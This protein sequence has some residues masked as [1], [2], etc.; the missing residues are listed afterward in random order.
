MTDVQ[1]KMLVLLLSCPLCDVK[2]VNPFR[3]RP[4]LV[5]IEALRSSDYDHW[6]LIL[7]F[8]SCGTLIVLCHSFLIFNME[9]IAV[10]SPL[11]CW[12]G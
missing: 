3:G 11:G 1:F 5:S 9:N 6:S 12:K 4:V 10:P 8:L 2:V 7:F